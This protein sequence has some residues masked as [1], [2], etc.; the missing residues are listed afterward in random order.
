V[1]WNCDVCGES[2]HYKKLENGKI[3]ALQCPIEDYK[4]VRSYL[5]DELRFLAGTFYDVPVTSSP[6]DLKILK[7]LVPE[8]TVLSDYISRRDKAHQVKSMIVSGNFRTFYLHFLRF[9]IDFYGDNSTHFIKSNEVAKATQFNYLWL[10][11][12]MMRECYFNKTHAKS[13]FK[14]MSDFLN[15]SLLIYG[16][17]SIDSTYMKNKGEIL[18]EVLTSRRSQGKPTWILHTKP[19]ADCDEVRTSENLR[20]YLANSS[21]IPRVHLDAAE[22]DPE[23]F[24]SPISGNSGTSG[25]TGRRASKGSSG[26]GDDPY[27]LM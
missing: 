1:A 8:T 19:F 26:T 25:R 2:I 20:L 14:T 16:L 5:T 10:T 27:N 3:V 17:G 15:P 9:L 13:K 21:F 4:T 18:M 23:I 7:S 11:E 22:E 12:T 24:G 6:E